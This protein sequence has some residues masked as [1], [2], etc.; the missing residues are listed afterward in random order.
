M[1]KIKILLF[2][3]VIQ[4]ISAPPSAVNTIFEERILNPNINSI[5]KLALIAVRN[6]LY[7]GNFAFNNTQY[8]QYINALNI[9][10]SVLSLIE[11]RLRTLNKANNL[12]ILAATSAEIFNGNIFY[13]DN[14]IKKNESE[15]H[16]N[17]INLILTNMEE[18]AKQYDDTSLTPVFKNQ[19]SEISL[20][21]NNI[22]KT[23]SPQQKFITRVFKNKAPKQYELTK[24]LFEK[25]YYILN[26]R[27]E[28]EN[29]ISERIQCAQNALIAYNMYF[30]V[31][32]EEKEEIAHARIAT[33]A[34]TATGLLSGINW[35]IA[36]TV[37]K[38]KITPLAPINE[39]IVRNSTLCLGRPILENI[40][41]F[42]CGM[43]L[44][45]CIKEYGYTNRSFA[46]A[47]GVITTQTVLDSFIKLYFPSAYAKVFS[48]FATAL[49]TT[50][51][52]LANI[53]NLES[54][55]CATTSAT[56]AYILVSS[57]LTNL[58]LAQTA[59]QINQNKSIFINDLILQIENS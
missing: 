52:S 49:S 55:S 41:L 5:D 23:T 45:N 28:I 44:T 38:P 29:I 2:I 39:T 47:D 11:G 10:D 51:T 26:S 4:T 33:I 48:L 25:C 13:V 6:A 34:L 16:K 32:S 56:Q 19:L 40:D 27:F 58:L 3:I 20:A 42:N 21:L 57:S 35:S 1:N 7:N 54:N 15:I 14:L 31:K 18:D 37:F 8:I 53:Q 22:Q 36:N 30:F 50:Q 24:E 12:M 59:M 46:I 17:A 9:H 43:Q